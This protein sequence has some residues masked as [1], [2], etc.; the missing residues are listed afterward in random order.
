MHRVTVSEEYVVYTDDI[1]IHLDMLWFESHHL[2][3]IELDQN[4][5]IDQ[6][7]LTAYS[8]FLQDRYI[9][10]FSVLFT[11]LLEDLA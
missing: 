1:Y 4:G 2:Q 9:K 10:S 3:K 5:N 6:Y 7:E 8:S 11:P